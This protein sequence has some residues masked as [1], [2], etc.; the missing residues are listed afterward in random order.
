MQ[1]RFPNR[2]GSAWPALAAAWFSAAGIVGCGDDGEPAADVPDAVDAEAA[3][4]DTD[5]PAEADAEADVP[6]EAEAEAGDDGGDAPEADVPPAEIAAALAAIPG[7]RVVEEESH[8]PG[9][10]AFDLRFRQPVDH[11]DP[12]RGTFEQYLSLLHRAADAPVVLVT[13]GYVNWEP[14]GVVE[15]T[16]MLEANQLVVEHRYFGD[17][18]PVPTDWS[19]LTIR[20]AA[21]DH[22]RIVEALAG[23]YGGAWISTGASKGG[24]TAVYHRRFHP[25]DVDG[26]VPYV[27]PISFGAPDPRYVPFVAAG[28]DAGCSARLHAL[29]RELLTR[30]DP[31][32]ALL[33]DYAAASGLTFVRMGGLET[34]F[35]ATVVELP[36]AFWQYHGLSE[37]PAVPGA[38]ASDRVLFEYLDEVSGFYWS[39]DW[40][41]DIF[42]AYYYQAATQ[43]GY[44]DVERDSLADL[45][46]T[47]FTDLE[48]GILPAGVGPVTYDP[49]VM[50]DVAGWV[51]GEGE[52]LLFVYGEFDPWTA[53]AFALGAAV[54]SYLLVVP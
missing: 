11:D 46:L 31:M 28:G 9:Y 37:C 24:M 3:D 40:L 29:Q 52:R 41:I 42:E 54:D 50:R 22:H 2:A 36:F 47:D 7:M 53:G 32:L 12:A 8:E 18:R 43:L 30:R 15:L 26:T 51:A 49:A 27:A 6:V 39:A 19:R 38:A 17:S 1:D 14:F 21:A 16:G 10:R 13:E 20:Q 35:E 33:D 25:D 45:L 34:T 23:I 5:V 48:S 44:P 4:A